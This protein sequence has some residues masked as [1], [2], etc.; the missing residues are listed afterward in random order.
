MYNRGMIDTHCHIHD[1]LVY[2]YVC[3]TKG[4][5]A[6]EFTPEK[7]AKR[8]WKNGVSGMICVGTTMEDS[9]RAREFVGKVRGRGHRIFWAYG[10]HPDESEKMAEAS[11]AE[12]EKDFLGA[13]NPPVAIGEIGLDFH[14]MK[15]GDNGKIDGANTEEVKRQIELLRKMLRLAKKYG[16][17][18]IF[19]VREAFP[20]FFRVV[21]SKEFREI[22]GVIHSFSDSEEIMRECL[23]RGFYIGMGGIVTFRKKAPL[24]PMERILL[25]TDAPFLT[26]VPYRKEVNEP[27][28]VRAT[29]E[30]L[31]ERYKVSTEEII[32]KADK[33]AEELFKI[34]Q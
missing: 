15:R 11:F 33:N 1:F 27:H 23:G 9:R 2:K 34:R 18:V 12:I 3:G 24:P 31:A 8:A 13:K 6:E 4:V 32:A 25:E 17:P 16:L 29:A 19:H 5:E 14:G 10:I 26:P 7:L 20:E 21:D 28:Y 30:F 22:T